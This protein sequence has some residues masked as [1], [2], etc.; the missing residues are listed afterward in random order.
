MALRASS[1]RV[2][3][4]VAFVVCDHV[5]LGDGSRARV[6]GPRLLQ[7][8]T[9]DYPKKQSL[10]CSRLYRHSQHH[11]PAHLLPCASQAAVFLLSL[12]FAIELARSRCSFNSFILTEA[13]ENEEYGMP[14]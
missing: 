2:I 8:A 3:A 7:V 10:M 14:V 12:V 4:V 1:V 13:Q 11:H 6:F 5:A 9:F